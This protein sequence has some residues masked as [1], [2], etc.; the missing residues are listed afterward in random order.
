MDDYGPP[1][2]HFTVAELIEALQH[3]P[4]DLPV[5]TTGY[6]NGYENFFEPRIRR[7][8]HE[9]ENLYVD[10]EFQPADDGNGD[11]LDAVILERVVRY[12]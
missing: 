4:H 6:N 9:P 3:M 8:K 12:D 2:F 11:V 10:G 1:E 7:L 5:V